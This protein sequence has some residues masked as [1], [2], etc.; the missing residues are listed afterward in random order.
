MKQASW[1]ISFFIFFSFISTTR[2]NTMFMLQ[3]K[4]TI[5][6]FFYNSFMINFQCK[7]INVMFVSKPSFKKPFPDISN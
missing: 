4:F 1:N 5:F 6:L 2:V 3:E 7:G